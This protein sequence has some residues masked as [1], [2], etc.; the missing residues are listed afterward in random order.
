[1][2]DRFPGDASVHRRN[3]TSLRSVYWRKSEYESFFALWK[4]ADPDVPVL[5]QA[6]RKYNQFHK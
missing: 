3:P 1:M 6:R 5:L 4:N 2:G